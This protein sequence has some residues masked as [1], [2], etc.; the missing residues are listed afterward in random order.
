[1]SNDEGM[2]KSEALMTKSFGTS[3]RLPAYARPPML[4][5]ELAMRL[6]GLD[7]DMLT[8][9]FGE[10]GVNSGDA[11]FARLQKAAATFWRGKFEAHQGNYEQAAARAEE[12]AE[13]VADDDNPR[14]MENY[15]EL[16]ALVAWKQG[17]HAKAIEHYGEANM[18]TAP[19][20]GD[21]K[22]AYRLAVSL[23]ET[24]ET[25]KAMAMMDEIANWNFNSAWFAMLRDDAT[26]G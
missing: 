24:G 26:Q 4:A 3:A 20:F 21:V 13:L 23:R 22:N 9:A 8:A 12:L 14:K 17:D 10:S 7:E 2:T 5:P 1:M 18:S 19:N 15:H 25:E 11:N 6:A 16:L